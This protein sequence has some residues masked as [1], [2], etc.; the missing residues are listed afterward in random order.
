MSE[1]VPPIREVARLRLEGHSYK[2]IATTLGTTYNQVRQ[3]MNRV[4]LTSP[5][6]REV[7]RVIMDGPE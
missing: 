5:Y 4:G 2:E 7:A 6:W 1:S 3:A